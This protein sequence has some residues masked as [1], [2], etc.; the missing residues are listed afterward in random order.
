MPA[1]RAVVFDFFGT[2]TRSVQRGPQHADIARA[3]GADP[4][5]VLGVLNRTFR[6]RACGRYG[7]AEATLRWV[8]EQAGGRPGPA[9]IRAAM[10]AR[11]DALRADTRLRP[12]AV[13]ALTEIRRRGV[14]TA[15]ISDCTHE[16]PAFLPGLPVAPLLDAQI[17]SVEQGVCKPDPRIY[18]AA[19]RELDV[20]PR[21]CLYVGDGGS[22]ELTGAAAVGMTPVRLAAHDLADHLVFDADTTFA[23]RTV[24][25]LS[26]VV[27][28]LDRTPAL[29]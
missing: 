22:Q 1:Y 15:L 23:G 6:A 26:E 16:L 11:V 14:R 2:L 27:A 24:R 4:E 3:L 10:P 18:L 20:E 8:I 12:D 13:S 9:A 21:D 28:L 19:C 17:F 29:V 25:S 5:A 7:S